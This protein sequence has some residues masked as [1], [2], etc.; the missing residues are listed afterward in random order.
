MGFHLKNERNS[1]HFPFQVYVD[2][3]MREE[4]GK[5][6][7]NCWYCGNCV[8]NVEIAG[9]CG[10]LWKT[11]RRVIAVIAEISQVPIPQG[12]RFGSRKRCG[13]D[14]NTFVILQPNKIRK[15]MA[16]QPPSNSG[17]S[18]QTSSKKKTTTKN[19][20]C[21]KIT[22]NDQGFFDFTFTI[23]TIHQTKINGKIKTNHINIAPGRFPKIL[24]FPPPKKTI[25]HHFSENAV[26]SFSLSVPP[27]RFRD[28]HHKQ[29]GSCRPPPMSR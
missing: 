23:V 24:C 7:E 14:G 16:I 3:R 8:K 29:S 27:D 18:R 20:V 28:A 25:L 21:L 2:G 13:T 10:K 15:G 12:L 1:L 26:L 11:C 22:K 9:K 6:R 17:W 5:L 19:A 4:R